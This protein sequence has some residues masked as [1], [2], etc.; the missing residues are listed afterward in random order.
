[1]NACHLEKI[2]K[3]FSTKQGEFITLEDISLDVEEGE[4][5]MITGP[6]RSGK[7]T[8]LSI[9]GGLLTPTSG[10]VTLHGTNLFEIGEH[11]AAQFRLRHI[12]FVFQTPQL[13]NSFTVFENI[14]VPLHL[15]GLPKK[16]A[17]ERALE[18]IDQ[19][20]LMLYKDEK[21][22]ILSETGKTLTA[23]ARALVL[24]PK[25]LILD[26]PTANL[27]HTSGVKILTH[28]RELAYDHQITVIAAITDVRLHPFADRVAKIR[29]GKIFMVSGEPG[30]IE[31]DT[32]FL[33]L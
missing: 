8:L 15:M 23:I 28:L 12:G 33:K 18:V 22:D 24:L 32:P 2:R 6:S 14:L 31:N 30:A 16:L 3:L 11:E 27:D 20:G 10:I 5:Y 21:P 29:E 17:G 1:M 4:V 7:T 13:I 25:I 9:I 26:E 19:L